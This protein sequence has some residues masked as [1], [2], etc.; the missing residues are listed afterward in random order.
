[1]R[2]EEN[3]S[4]KLQVTYLPVD[5]EGRRRVARIASPHKCGKS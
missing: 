3:T 1:M 5:S 4:C 2:G